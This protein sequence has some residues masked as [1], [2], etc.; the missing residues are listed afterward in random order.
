MAHRRHWAP[1]FPV[2]M[3]LAVCLTLFWTLWGGQAAVAGQ[4]DQRTDAAQNAV[5]SK[6]DVYRCYTNHKYGYVIAWPT[7]LLQAQGESAAGDGQIFKAADGRAKL[8]CWAMY[9]D[10]VNESLQEMFQTAQKASSFHVTYTHMGKR[11][12]VVSG[13]TG[14]SI[15]YQKTIQNS[16]IIATFVLTYDKALRRIF[17]PIVGDI[18]KSFNANTEF[19][20]H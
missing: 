13:T 20:Y 7:K 19:M 15:V 6:T 5:C 14:N 18:A 3:A 12:F 10:V 4:S 17:N 8:L 16:R 9:T 1:V 11:F 2:R